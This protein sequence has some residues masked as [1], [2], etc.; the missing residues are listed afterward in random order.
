MKKLL[1]Y[2]HNYKLI[3]ALAPLF[4]LLEA[5]LELLVPLIIVQIIDKVVPTAN[6]KLLIFYIGIM[7]LVA[8]VSWFFSIM[9]QFFAAKSAVGFTKNLTQDLFKKTLTL[10]Q[11]SY[12]ELTPGS[13]TA[14]ITNDTYQIQTG[15]NL[16]FRLFLRSPFIV[17]GSLLMA[18]RINTRM[19]LYFIVMTILLTLVI[20]G[21]IR[22][23]TPYQRKIREKFDDLVTSTREQMKGLRVIRAFRQE[24]REQNE[25]KE[26]N[27][28]LAE[29]QKKTGYLAILT[30]PLTF[31]IVNV[32]LILLIWDG[33]NLVDSGILSQ[34]QIVA[35]V[36][37]LLAILI[38]L[39]KLV[40]QTVRIN[41]A[42][43]SAGRVV[44]VLGKD[45]E[46]EEFA[47]VIDRTKTY[48]ELPDS[49]LTQWNEEETAFLFNDVDFQY[50]TAEKKVLK[51]IQF[52]VKKNSLFGIIG[53]TGSGKTTVLNLISNIYLPTGGEIIYDPA[54]LNNS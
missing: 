21:V 41:R 23:T 53:G 30:N 20:I 29:V 44:K 5:L 52:E 10:S 33:S 2:F 6:K 26:L 43:V 28:D 15:L 13:L 24:E 14:R 37:Y 46:S 36:N 7:F 1:K 47:K 40:M 11:S 34:G 17:M 48:D 18:S 54:I 22:I 4:K 8:L 19:T 42:W 35:L 51:N 38:E 45:S 9:G 50:P 31:L 16:F 25:F 3:S 39:A 12:D 49:Q 32:I 27:W